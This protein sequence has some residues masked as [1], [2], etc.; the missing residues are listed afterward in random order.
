MGLLEIFHIIL[1]AFL[2]WLNLFPARSMH[3][4]YNQ[5]KKFKIMNEVQLFQPKMEFIAYFSPDDQASNVCG[6]T[7]R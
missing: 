3:H 6:I 2:C 7:Q 1:Y 5:E 4:I